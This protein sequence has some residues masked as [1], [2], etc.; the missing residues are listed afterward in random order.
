MLSVGKWEVNQCP[1]TFRAE[2]FLAVAK[3]PQID[4]VTS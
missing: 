4:P 2:A 1:V 3:C